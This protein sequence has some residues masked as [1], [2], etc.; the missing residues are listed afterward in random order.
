[1]ITT[2][3]IIFVLIPAFVAAHATLA[4]YAIQAPDLVE[5]WEISE[6]QA[7]WL[8]GGFMLAYLPALVAS[9]GAVK[10]RA[11]PALVGAL[12]VAGISRLLYSEVAETF[13]AAFI[14]ELL[15]GAA[16]AVVLASISRLLRS[17]PGAG[18]WLIALLSVLSAIVSIL[19]PQAVVFVAFAL[20]NAFLAM[21]YLGGIAALLW[22]LICVLFVPSMRPIY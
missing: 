6:T 5:L 18:V 9:W 15:D 10:Y 13:A 17:R 1:M 7:A 4:V 2:V 3:R 11:K 22:A 8:N 19:G 21:H 12:L 20:P 16:A 14:L